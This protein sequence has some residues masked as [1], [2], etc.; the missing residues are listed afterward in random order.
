MNL[1]LCSVPSSKTRGTVN[2]HHC[3]PSMERPSPKSRDWQNLTGKEYWYEK[4]TLRRSSS[5]SSFSIEQMRN[6]KQNLGVAWV[7]GQSP[8]PPSHTHT[9]HLCIILHWF[10]IFI[11]LVSLWIS[12]T[13]YVLLYHVTLCHS[14]PLTGDWWSWLCWLTSCWPAHEGR[15]W[16]EFM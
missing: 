13:V 4:C 15:T 12:S 5:S 8:P 7:W 14:L 16:G 6:W 3:R 2:Y 1:L 11:S 9:T 10:R